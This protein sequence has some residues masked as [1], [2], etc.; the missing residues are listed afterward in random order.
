M[1][2]ADLQALRKSLDLNQADMAA[3]IGMSTRAYQ[4]LEAGESAIRPVHVLAVDQIKQLDIQAKS[5]ESTAQNKRQFENAK[6]ALESV[7]LIRDYYASSK[8]GCDLINE[9]VKMIQNSGG[10]GRGVAI[11]IM[12]YL[13]AE[14]HHAKFLRECADQIEANG[15]LNLSL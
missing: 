2:P 5:R 11:G 10:I 9:T 1:N 15:K 6:R 7:E 14:Q 13:K 3:R 12:L 4:A 8:E